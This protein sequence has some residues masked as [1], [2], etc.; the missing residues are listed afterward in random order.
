MEVQD[1]PVD[2]TE[3]PRWLWLT[4]PLVLLG[5]LVLAYVSLDA[6]TYHHWFGRELGFVEMMTPFL[7]LFAIA[8]GMRSLMLLRECTPVG[9]LSGWVALVSLA[10]F[11]FAGEEVSWGQQLF[12]WDTPA[13]LGA[14]ND[15]DETNLH[16]ISSWFDQKPRLV[17]ELLVLTGGVILPLC[18]RRG[19]WFWPTR[20]C[21][22]AALLAILVYMPDRLAVLFTDQKSFVS[23][24]LSEI[25]E[26][27]YAVFFL[28][29]MASLH[30]RLRIFHAG[31]KPAG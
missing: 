28:I 15:Q 14:I 11:Y 29:Y 23:I 12:H 26:L 24:R 9:R 2:G 30:A 25:Q 7:L 16:N 5:V 18:G 19:T 27:F 10:C 13:A 3:V 1:V 21:L 22:P 4:F 31:Q 6:D 8:Y 17:V 20:A